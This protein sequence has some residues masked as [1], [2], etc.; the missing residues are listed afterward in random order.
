MLVRLRCVVA[1]PSV[2]STRCL[3][4]SLAVAGRFLSVGCVGRAAPGSVVAVPA[5]VVFVPIA[6]TVAVASRSRPSG[7][8]RATVGGTI[9]T[10]RII[11]VT[12]TATSIRA[13]AAISGRVRT[14]ITIITVTRIRTATIT[15]RIR[16]VAVASVTFH[17]TGVTVLAIAT[18]RVRIT[19]TASIRTAPTVAGVTAIISVVSSRARAAISVTTATIPSATTAI[20]T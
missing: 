17:I 2:V 14:T 16:I 8:I 4:A 9:P 13:V 19:T 3:I 20:R 6:A 18:A 10:S 15:G 5:S 1:G 12:I 7:G 11:A